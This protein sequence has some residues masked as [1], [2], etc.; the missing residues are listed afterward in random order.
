MLQKGIKNVKT[1]HRRDLPTK[2]HQE[3]WK[4][5]DKILM[6]RTNVT[7]LLRFLLDAFWFANGASGAQKARKVLDVGKVEVNEDYTDA[8]LSIF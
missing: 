2:Y 7:G 8:T 4:S 3:A 1:L 6:Y 5:Y